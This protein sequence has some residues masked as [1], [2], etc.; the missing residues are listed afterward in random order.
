MCSGSAGSSILGSSLKNPIIP[1]NK[2]IA[3]SYKFETNL[4]KNIEPTKQLYL[5]QNNLNNILITSKLIPKQNENQLK[6][7]IVDLLNMNILY[8]LMF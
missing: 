3:N 6:D 5:K 2:M 4:L 8:H 7:L 1:N